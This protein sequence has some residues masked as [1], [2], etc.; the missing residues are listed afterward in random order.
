MKRFTKHAFHNISETLTD[1]ILVYTY[2]RVLE[3]SDYSGGEI[4]SEVLIKGL[5]SDGLKSQAH[6]E[7]VGMS[8]LRIGIKSLSFV[9]D[10]LFN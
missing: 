5:I 1:K 8:L 2:S 7:Q 10:E 3:S 6:C 9:T 4:H